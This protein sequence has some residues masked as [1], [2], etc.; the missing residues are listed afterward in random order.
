[1]LY[2]AE[3]GEV[4]AAF[5]ALH[6]SVEGSPSSFSDSKVCARV[7]SN[8]STGPAFEC[9]RPFVGPPLALP[10]SLVSPVFASFLS[11]C[12]ADL[13]ATRA[14]P[15]VDWTTGGCQLCGRGNARFMQSTHSW[16][17]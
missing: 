6:V 7:Q 14:T 3:Q 15:R 17:V 13:A 1:M 9:F 12:K 2:A 8:S 16:C 10:A 11:D 4:S 5:A